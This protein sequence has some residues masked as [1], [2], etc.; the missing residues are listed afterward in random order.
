M[1]KNILLTSSALV[2]ALSGSVFAGGVDNM[3]PAAPAAAACTPGQF[4]VAANGGFTTFTG[5]T[6]NNAGAE[7]E[8]KDTNKNGFNGQLAF[9]YNLSGMPVSLQLKGM[10]ASFDAKA[11]TNNKLTIMGATVD[12]VYD[13][14]MGSS[15]TPYVGAGVGYG[16][17]KLD[18]ATPANN[19][20][21]EK[22]G[23]IYDV[24]AGV[25]YKINC[26]LEATLG[27]QL[28]G[29]NVKVEGTPTTNTTDFSSVLFHSINVGLHYSF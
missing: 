12:A 13:I 11:D 25:S 22:N 24:M 7:T 28:T 8:F 3:A 23:L 1:N 6:K 16:Q 29:T 14:D 4:Y 18:K 2:L 17:F 15:F 26:N 19:L 5:K 9:G 21:G 10:F 20:D 27:Y